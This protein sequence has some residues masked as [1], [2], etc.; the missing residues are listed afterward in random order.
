MVESA[1]A[2][3]SDKSFPVVSA[4]AS[5]CRRSCTSSSGGASLAAS[6]AKRHATLMQIS[7]PIMDRRIITGREVSDGGRHQN[8]GVN[9]PARAFFRVR[10]G[11][12]DS[13]GAE[14]DSERAKILFQ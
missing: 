12:R 4:R 2:Y 8:N 9:T 10:R 14:V 5:N 1:L 7:G 11:Q 3:C 6:C 13:V